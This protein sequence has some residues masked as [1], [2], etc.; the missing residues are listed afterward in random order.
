M[1]DFY[2]SSFGDLPL[3]ISRIYTDKSRSQVIHE[4]SAGDDYVVQDR[5]QAPLKSRVT[6]L[7]DWMNGDDL[8]PLDR[9]RKFTALVDDKPRM[10][11]HPVEGTFLARVG[12]WNYDVDAS[13]VISGEAELIRVGD[14]AAVSPAGAG[15]IPAAGDG[16]VAAAADALDLELEGIGQPSVLPQQAAAAVDGWAA[17]G[18]PNPRDVLTQTGSLTQRLGDQ[19]AGFESD[20][21]DWAAFKATLLLAESVR[22][23]AESATADTASTFVVKIGSTIALR[24]LI[25][26]IYGADEADRRY[27]QAM[28]LNDIANPAWIEPGT[29]LVL[30]QSPPPPRTA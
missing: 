3:W 19:A 21:N 5:G 8:A 7:F 27:E 24:A 28:Q 30:P 17:Q 22:A 13:G 18:T 15:G 9:L 6:I 11:T 10:F 4:L 1:A 29:E 25:A 16:A 12:A 14:V 20:L 23:A 2:R 26:S